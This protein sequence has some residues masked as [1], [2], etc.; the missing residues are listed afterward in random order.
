[1]KDQSLTHNQKN[2]LS[3]GQCCEE[4]V[5]YKSAV[6]KVSHDSHPRLQKISFITLSPSLADI[7]SRRSSVSTNERF[8][9]NQFIDI[10]RH[11]TFRL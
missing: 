1:M 6:T 4:E 5:K 3:P 10:C 8:E 2:Y 9:Q 11:I 7:T